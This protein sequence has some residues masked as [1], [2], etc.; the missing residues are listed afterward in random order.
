MDHTRFVSTVG[1]TLASVEPTVAPPVERPRAQA[2]AASAGFA[3]NAVPLAVASALFMEFID[4]TALIHGPADPGA[5]P[6]IP[7]RST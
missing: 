2:P 4:S 1:A 7:I 3:A 6:S 5:T